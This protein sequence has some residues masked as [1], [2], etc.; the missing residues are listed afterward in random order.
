MNRTGALAVA[1]LGLLGL[2]VVARGRWPDAS[3][4]LD[5][6]PGAVRVVDGVARCGDG[7]APSASQRLLLGQK[8]DLNSVAEGELARVPGVGPSLARRLVQ[9]R[10]TRGRFVSWEEVAS[11]PGVGAARLETLQATTELR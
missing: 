9:A 5:C 4:A 8:L 11:V 7:A 1:S 6:E 3:P 2:G 10:E